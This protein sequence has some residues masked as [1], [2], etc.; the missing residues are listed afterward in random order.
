MRESI[1]LAIFTCGYGVLLQLWY[2]SSPGRLGMLMAESGRD[3]RVAMRAMLHLLHLSFKGAYLGQWFAET[4]RQV[5][6]RLTEYPP[7]ET[8]DHSR[9]LVRH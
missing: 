5:F 3:R 9:Y 8:S 4:G 1:L 6:E 2:L 7:Y